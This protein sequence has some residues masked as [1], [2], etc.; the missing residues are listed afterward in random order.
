[1]PRADI[2]H[3]SKLIIVRLHYWESSRLNMEICFFI[4]TVILLFFLLYFFFLCLF[5][6]LIN[7]PNKLLYKDG[8]YYYSFTGAEGEFLG[9]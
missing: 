6:L 2:Y 8:K 5:Y 9:Y 1:M 3:Q 4:Q 7:D